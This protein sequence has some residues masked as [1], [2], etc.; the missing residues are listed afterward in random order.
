MEKAAVDLRRLRYFIAI[1]EHGGFSRASSSVGIA[2][3]SLTRQIKLLEKELGFALFHRTGRGAGPTEQGRLLLDRSKPHLEGIDD[4]VREVRRRMSNLSGTVAL[5]VCPTIAPLF[6][7]DLRIRIGNAHPSVKLSVVEAYSGDL[8]SMMA[9]GSIDMALTYTPTERR[10]VASVELLSEPLVL[11]VPVDQDT[12]EAP[13]ALDRIAGLRLILP[14]AIHEL[15]RIIDGISR[16]RGVQLTPDIEMDSLGAVKSMLLADGARHATILPVN[17]V[18]AEVASGR[19]SAIEI[20]DPL[21]RR[22]IAIVCP[23]SGRNA[24]L[25][26]AMTALIQKRAAALRSPRPPAGRVLLSGALPG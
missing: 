24:G 11:V 20:D 18:S 25:T 12:W 6:I 13:Q 16:L 7:D 23:R 10:G 26:Q 1:C 2:Q 5:G 14:S 21:M 3:P 17:S 19:L 4:A 15:R 22:T 9:H 8:A